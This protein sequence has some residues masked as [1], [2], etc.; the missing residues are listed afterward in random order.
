MNAVVDDP[1][2]RLLAA[3]NAH[4]VEA[5]VACFADDYE[6]TSPVHPARSF[7]GRDQVRRNWTAILGAVPDLNA[8]IVGRARD[9]ETVWTE[10]EMTGNRRD[11]AVHDMRG[12]FVFR[13]RDGLVRSGRMYLEPVDRDAGDMDR[14]VR[15]QLGAR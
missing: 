13:V 6:L 2:E 5:I 4:D 12:V 11:G 3:T 10:W 1:I 7:R 8:R 15:D 14:A 9:G